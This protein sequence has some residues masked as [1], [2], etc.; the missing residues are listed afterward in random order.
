MNVTCPSCGAEMDLDVLLA[1]EDSRQALAQLAAISLPLGKVVLQYLRLFKPATRAMS[2]SRTVKLIT[3]L[4]PD[5][6]R[7][8]IERKGRE[9]DAPTEAWRIAIEHVLAMRDKGALTLPLTSHGYLYEVLAGMADKVEAKAESEVEQRRRQRRGDGG[10]P[11]P[12]A[13]TLA[14]APAPAPANYSTPSPYALRL[15]AEIAAKRRAHDAAPPEGG[16]E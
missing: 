5:L 4:L 13:A 9:W 11:Q 8:S 7:Q 16:A 14:S 6:Q 12:A 15:Q 10:A 3:E 1:H 2:H